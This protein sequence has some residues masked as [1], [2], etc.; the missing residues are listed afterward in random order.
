[1]TRCR[2]LM[3]V[4]FFMAAHSQL[5]IGQYSQESVD[6]ALSIKIADTH[7]HFYGSNGL[8]VPEMVAQMDRNNVQWGGGVGAY[9]G[10]LHKILGERYFGFMGDTE[11]TKVLFNDGEK[12]LQNVNHPVFIDMFSLAEKMFLENKTRG[13][14]EIHIDNTDT[15]GSSGKFI[16]KIPLDSPVIRQMYAIA[17]AHR[18]FVQIHINKTPDA[19]RDIK[20][21]SQTFPNATTILSHCMPRST[22]NDLKEIF[23]STTNVFCELSGSGY[24]H[25][26]LRIYIQT[27][28]RSVWSSLV[29]EYP[30]RIMV[31]SDP[32]CGLHFK[33][34]EIINTLRTQILAYLKPETIEKVAYKNAVRVF[35]LK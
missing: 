5:A 22:P 20:T 28:M 11:F 12:G 2:F 32:C 29:E 33:Y 16:R 30:E 7:M 19:V 10:L 35:N 3:W 14:G 17:N 26:N 25:G 27:G 13:F 18:G 6:L 15:K 9:N 31:G 8:E 34:D 1:M 23:S 21:I 24:L 4:F